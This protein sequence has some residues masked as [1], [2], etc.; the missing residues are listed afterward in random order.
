MSCQ[1]QSVRGHRESERWEELYFRTRRARW[2]RR[3]RIRPFGLRRGERVVEIG[4]GDG[5]NLAVL[6]AQGFRRLVG[7]DLSL[8]LLARVRAA[9]VF[10]A[11]LFALSVRDAGTDV[12]LVDSVLHHV[13]PL[14]PALGELFRALRPGGR[15]CILEP[16]PSLPRRLLE[17]AMD[18][19]PFPPPLRARQL[20]YFEER[21]VDHAW[22]RYFPTFRADL[23]AAGFTILR[24]RPLP[25]GV[26]VTCGRP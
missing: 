2:L 23:E 6:R 17:G 16:R 19:V 3:G 15:L 24:W 26:A 13:V 20:T 12:F 8:P 5:L 22:N 1:A 4:C 9:P 18:R 10:A 11:D 7:T 14:A 21:D 25:F